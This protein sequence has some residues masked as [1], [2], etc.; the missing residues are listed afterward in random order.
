MFNKFHQKCN[1]SNLEHSLL[2]PYQLTDIDECSTSGHGCD[3]DCVNTE[4]SYFCQCKEG[5]ALNSDGRSCRISCDKIFSQ[6][7]GGFQTPD[8]P[9]TYP[10]ADFTCEWIV[11]TSTNSSIQFTVDSSAYGI[12]GSPPCTHD[13]LEFFD[14]IDNHSPSLGRFCK[15]RVPPPITT[16]SGVARV[17]FVGTEHD[18]RPASRK[19]ARIVFTATDY[20]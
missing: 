5:Y 6:E 11:N 15:L 4:G 9:D 8:W 12:N 17:I 16:S 3:Q 10:Q 19:G 1:Y 2:I 13:Y 18:S 14:G 20:N 7:S